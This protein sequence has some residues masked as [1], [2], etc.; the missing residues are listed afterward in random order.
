[1]EFRKFLLVHPQV[2]NKEKI[3]APHENEW[4]TFRFDSLILS[5]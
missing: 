5:C 1:M 3:S 2:W 4:Q